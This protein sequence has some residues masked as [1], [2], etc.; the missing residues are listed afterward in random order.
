MCQLI[1]DNASTAEMDRYLEL[2]VSVGLPI[3]L[4]DLGIGAATDAAPR[5]GGSK[6]G[7]GDRDDT[8]QAR[9]IA[10]G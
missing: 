4:A 7:G 1:L 3:E 10:G 8:H 9:R 5:G 2:M 6:E